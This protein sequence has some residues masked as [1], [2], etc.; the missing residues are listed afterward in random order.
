M[1]D[2][3]LVELIGK[4]GMAVLLCGAEIRAEGFGKDYEKLAANRNKARQAILAHVENILKARNDYEKRLEQK[5]IKY[6]GE[7]RILK[8]DR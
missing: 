7:L 8:K 6:G 3:K 4:H 1:T 5:V 2:K